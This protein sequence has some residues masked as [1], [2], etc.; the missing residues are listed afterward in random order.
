MG[1]LGRYGGAGRCWSSV[2]THK[3]E[4]QIEVM[5]M[6]AEDSQ[7]LQPHGDERREVVQLG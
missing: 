1:Y 3:E 5:F 7:E 6:A 2:S 4:V